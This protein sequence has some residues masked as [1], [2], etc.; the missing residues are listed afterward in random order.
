MVELFLRLAAAGA[1]VGWAGLSPSLGLAFAGQGAGIFA[2]VS[3]F[4]FLLE[5][6]EL[7]SPGISTAAAV[8]DAF[9]IAAILSR[10]GQMDRF[11]A[12]CAIPILWASIRHQANPALTGPLSAGAMLASQ[13][14][15]GIVGLTWPA[16]VNALLTACLG[17][18]AQQ[19]QKIVTITKIE[20]AEPTILVPVPEAPDDYLE[21]RENFRQL[22]DHASVLERRSRRDKLGVQTYQAVLS[23]L[24]PPCQA[25]AKKMMDGCGATGLTLYTVSEFGDKMIVQSTSGDVPD[26][27]HS[28]S[29]DTPLKAPEGAI[30]H[31]IEKLVQTIRPVDSSSGTVMLKSR[32][33]I[34]GMACIFAKNPDALDESRTRL[35]EAGDSL[36]A[37]LKL[38]IDREEEARR[39]REVELLYTVACTASGSDTVS[40][41]SQRVV[42][43]LSDMLAVDHMSLWVLDGSQPHLAA[44]KGAEDSH[45]DI[46]RLPYGPGLEGW[47]AAGCPEL[48]LHDAKSDSRLD[49]RETVRRRIGSYILIPIL[50]SQKTEALLVA[51]SSRIHGLDSSHLETLRVVASEVGQAFGRLGS[52]IKTSEGLATPKEL[53]SAVQDSGAGCLVYMEIPRREELADSYGRAALAQAIAKFAQRIRSRLPAGALLCRRDEGDYVA[54][55]RDMNEE[56]ATSWANEAAATAS[57]IALTTPDGRARIPLALKAKTAR[58]DRSLNLASTESTNPNAKSA[59]TRTE[60]VHA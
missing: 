37:T 59:P 5:R 44:R 49:S 46:L 47:V 26:Q 30:R 13:N 58:I 28:A 10:G 29:F 24:E 22:R 25:M 31:K 18:L 34:V 32:G 51:T 53:F 35:E 48:A 3:I 52:G 50:T 12:A 6:K 41:L 55:L 40:T 42:R 14:L 1:A 11:G 54:Y 45:F 16:L 20:E 15:F 19:S 8:G 4:L 39:L 17:L 60:R 23:G 2:A 38:I 27:L 57:M 9:F 33:R 7:R 36:G 43:E 56:A 21:L